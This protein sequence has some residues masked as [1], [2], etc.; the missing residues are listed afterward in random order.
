MANNLAIT[1]PPQ[2]LA[3][4]RDIHLPSPIGWWPL[5]PGWYVLAL[6]VLITLATTAYFLTRHYI[7]NRAKRQALKLLDTYREQYQQ[8]R[9]QLSAARVSELLKRVALVYFPRSNVASLQGEAW[10]T[11]LT[12]SSKGLD[13]E[14][15]RAELL[16]GPYQSNLSHD[17]NLLFQMAHTWIRQR[18][19]PC[20]N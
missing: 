9:H 13:F 6:L 7:K 20:S 18:R 10:I 11:F 15:V 8:E 19:R 2:E 4:L 1:P 5:A 14:K 17:L 3:Q 12:D 16:E